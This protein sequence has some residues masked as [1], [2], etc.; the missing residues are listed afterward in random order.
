MSPDFTG[1]N[2]PW[3]VLF[4]SCFENTSSRSKKKKCECDQEIPQ[5][6]TA[7]QPMVPRGR[8]TEHLQ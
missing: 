2:Y 6:H 3:V 4:Q 5:S 8:A 1:M 7:D